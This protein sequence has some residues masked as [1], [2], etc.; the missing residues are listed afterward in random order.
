MLYS[1]VIVHGDY[2]KASLLRNSRLAPSA[3]ALV[4]LRSTS[5]SLSGAPL[6][7]SPIGK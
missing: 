4:A 7:H 5:R 1:T 2:R 6:S 3:P